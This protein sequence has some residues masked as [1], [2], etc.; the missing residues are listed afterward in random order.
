M[1]ATDPSDST[2]RQQAVDAIAV[3]ISALDPAAGQLSEATDFTTDLSL[4]SMA[5]ND[6]MFA[7]EERFDVSIPL[8]LLIDVHTVGQLADLIVR[9]KAGRRG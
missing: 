4:D 3:E 2:L 8:N 9:Q 6:L 5:I 1:A 7:L